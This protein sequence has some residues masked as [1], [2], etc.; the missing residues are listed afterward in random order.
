VH[1]NQIYE[2]FNH[3]HDKGIID[4]TYIKSEGDSS[5]PILDVMVNDIKVTY[6]TLDGFNWVEGSRKENL[7]YFRHDIDSNFYFK[8]SY[9]PMLLDIKP[10]KTKIFP[11]GLNYNFSPSV[12]KVLPI[13]Q[14][15]K[16]FLSHIP[17]LK[18]FAPK[19]RFSFEDFENLPI[20]QKN[21]NILFM[22]RLWNPEDTQNHQ[23][24][25]KW[26]KINRVRIE[27]I[28]RCREAYG[29]IFFGGLLDDAFSR[30]IAPD[31]ILSK[32][33]TRKENYINLVKKFD[34]CIASTGLHDSIGWKFGE[35][36]SLS[37]AIV[38]EPLH[39]EL[40]GNF[41]EEI[42]YLAF[43]DS[44]ELIKKVDRLLSDRTYMV[45]MMTRNYDYYLLYLKPESLVLRSLLTVFHESGIS[46]DWS[47]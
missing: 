33:I 24:K 21:S 28:R 36:V 30:S 14:R 2:G 31:L 32:E 26:E 39:Y 8:R 46:Y 41:K 16:E 34:I 38:S 11:L 42:N 5:K 9:S 12:R 20:P 43:N 37:R 35:Y 47:R 17:F 22:A 23:E 10:D 44:D 15:L 29:D 25:A 1:L 6:D 7:D 19:F 4:A 3:L 18:E 27:C 13:R 40:P 45:K